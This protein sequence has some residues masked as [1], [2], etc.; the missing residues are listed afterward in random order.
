MKDQILDTFKDQSEKMFAPSREMNKLAVS[1]LEKLASL[2]FASL[3]EYTEM[4]LARLKAA[5]DINTPEALQEY[6]AQQRDF[7]KTVGEKLTSDAKAM[8]ELGKEFT[9]EAQKIA[10]DG[11]AAA[12]KKVA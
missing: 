4:N 12:G 3:R 10:R 7:M 2:Q 1:K 6:F 5:T 8:T 9:E 11:F